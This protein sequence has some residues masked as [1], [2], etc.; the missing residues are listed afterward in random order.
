VFFDPL[1]GR[2]A[3]LAIAVSDDAHLGAAESMDRRAGAVMR[4]PPIGPNHGATP[5]AAATGADTPVD[6]SI[7]SSIAPDE[8]VTVNVGKADMG[9]HVAG[10]TAQIA[11]DELGPPWSAMRV[12]LVGNDPKYNYLVLGANIT[13]IWSTMVNFEQPAAGREQPAL[14]GQGRYPKKKRIDMSLILL[15]QYSNILSFDGVGQSR[16]GTRNGMTALL[17]TPVLPR[18]LV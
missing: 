2:V 13:G 12:S 3:Y 7:W 9:Q 6:P 18:R 5:A 8:I 1:L 16:C 17:R 14:G 15:N 4:L 10:T 11:A